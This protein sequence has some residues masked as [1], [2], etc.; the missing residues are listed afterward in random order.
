MVR[1][2]VERR[3]LI[4]CTVTCFEKKRIGSY[5]ALGRQ[6]EEKVIYYKDEL[7]DEFSTAVIEAKKID[8]NYT[9]VYSGNWKKF[10][11]FFWYRVIATPLAFLYMKL[12]F[13]HKIVNKKVLKEAKNTGWFL[14]GNHTHFMADALIPTMISTPTDMYVIVH[15]DNVSMPYLGRITPSLGALPLPDDGAA[16]RKFLKAIE[17][18]IQEKHG[19]TIYPEAHIWPYY[20]KIRPFKDTSF[21][22][23]IKCKVP[24]FCFT[25]TYQK[26]RFRKTPRIVTYVDGPFYPEEKLSGQEQRAELRDRV[27]QTMTERSQNSN[28]ERIKYMKASERLENDGSETAG[29]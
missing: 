24:T 17:T 25:N 1:D 22:Y 7:N 28:V 23:P 9:Y 8:G 29:V 15:P 19:V 20:T 2:I 6:M 16:A 18:R 4:L 27:Y 10:T 3:W 11:H 13:G 5:G 26:R 21:R 14:F 12:Y